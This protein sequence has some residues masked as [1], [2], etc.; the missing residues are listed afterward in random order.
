MLRISFVT[1]HFWLILISLMLLVFFPGRASAAE[2]VFSLDQLIG[3]ALENSPELRM[4]DQEII[5]AG[6]DVKRA[7]AAELP[8]LDLRTLVGPVNEASVPTVDLN[9]GKLQVRAIA[10]T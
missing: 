2:K 1:K 4:A 10:D 7:S 5:A 6:S 8:Q 3:M 9:K